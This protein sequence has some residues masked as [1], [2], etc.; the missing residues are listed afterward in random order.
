MEKIQLLNKYYGFAIN[1]RDLLFTEGMHFDSYDQ[2]EKAKK[3]FLFTYTGLIIMKMDDGHSW[4]IY[5]F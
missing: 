3:P 2:N 5:H 4:T 1:W